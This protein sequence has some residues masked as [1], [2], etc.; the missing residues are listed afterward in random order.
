MR[1]PDIQ[2]QLR[3]RDQKESVEPWPQ[4]I[5]QEYVVS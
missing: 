2:N 4:I 3:R 5:N 1:S